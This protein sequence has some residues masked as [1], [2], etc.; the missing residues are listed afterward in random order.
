LKGLLRRTELVE[1]KGEFPPLVIFPEG[2]CSNNTTLTKFRRGAFADM[3]AVQPI[4]LKYKHGMVHPAIES[5]DEPFV[6][7][8]MCCTLTPVFVEVK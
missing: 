6:V 7:F 8:L 4:T 3:R 5:M 1:T 2:T